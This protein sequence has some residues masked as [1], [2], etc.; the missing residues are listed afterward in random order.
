MKKSLEIYEIAPEIEALRMGMGFSK[1]DLKRPYV[2]IE[3]TYGDSH[4]GSCGLD[5]L[6]DII[7]ETL[8][9]DEITSGKFFSTDI[10]D[11]IAQGHEGMNYSLPSREIIAALSEIH[12]RANP[13]EGAVF[14]SSCDKAIPAHL[15]VLARI[16]KPA[17]LLPGGVM[18]EGRN[19][20]TLE[21]VGKYNVDYKRGNL[22]KEQ[23]LE[24]KK[25]ACTTCGAC[26]FMGTAGTMQ[27]LAEALGI[28]PP[29]S[30][31]TPYESD[32]MR[33]NAVNAVKYL[34]TLMQKDILPKNI[35][36]K[37]AFENAAVIFT[38]VGG[39]TNAMLHLP[40]LANE[41]GI[42]FGVEDV[43]RIGQKVYHM[44][45]T[46]PQGK[47]PTEILWEAGCV[48]AIM[49]RVKEYL[50]LD[51]M[52]C[53]GKTLGENMAS[54][55][56]EIER[57]LKLLHARG[58]RQSDVIKRMGEKGSLAFLKGNIAKEGAIVKY[59]AIESGKRYFKGT[60]RVFND[61][62]SAREAIIRKEICKGTVI[63]IRYC[64]PK[65]IGMPE[66][67]YTTEALAS[68]AELSATTAIITDGRFSGASRGPNIG[69][70]CPEAAAGGEIAYI[71]DGDCIEIDIEK[72]SINLISENFDELMAQRK[73][74][75][76]PKEFR[77]KGILGLYCEKAESSIRGGAM[78]K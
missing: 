8:Y 60:A 6:A 26:Q 40:A 23:F 12:L 7:S 69:H 33:E 14:I 19:K 64:G 39:S 62:V 56:S 16:D 5:K 46:R 63:V 76:K 78:I 47:Y 51:V 3:S 45:D 71:E 41:L 15:L 59:S 57:N 31:L 65:A 24:I 18:R 48:P 34:E 35:L 77:H 66:L 58:I 55:E 25:D 36:T 30:A 42:G 2:L 37:E 1:E 21:Q 28:A 75:T 61:E 68:D 44:T 50:H 20:M 54:F 49:L 73:A 67:F 29:F 32:A 10:C 4:P 38:C 72:R 27:V 53:T 70:I 17:L 9:K 11:G 13:C 74:K 43:D 52:T 22:S